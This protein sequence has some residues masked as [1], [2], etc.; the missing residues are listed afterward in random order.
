MASRGD[1]GMRWPHSLDP[2]LPERRT[3]LPGWCNGSAGFVH[4]WTLA[5]SVT[6]DAAYDELAERSAWSTWE[7][8]SDTLA[9]IC[10]GLA[11]MSYALLRRDRAAPGGGWFARAA[12]LASRA[13]RVV[14]ADPPSL[15]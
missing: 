8:A 2:R 15:P 13:A 4:L 9:T 5:A 1:V 7:Q 10:C 3:Y 6:G 12:A 14:A 11:G